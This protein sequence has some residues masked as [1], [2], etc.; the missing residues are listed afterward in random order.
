MVYLD[1]SARA[2]ATRAAELLPVLGPAPSTES[3]ESAKVIDILRRHGEPEP[4]TLTA[5]DISGMRRVARELWD[6]FAASSTEQAAE[7]LNAILARY[8]HAPRLSRH[9]AT[10]WHIHVDR[11]DDGPWT[12]WFAASSAMA[13]ATLLSERQTNPAGLC[14]SPTCGRPF[15][16]SGQGAPQRYCSPRCATRERVAAHRKRAA[17]QR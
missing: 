1:G 4:I 3:G 11:H 13:L 16:D 6:V 12:E 8:A 7:Q 2:A 10:A 17:R 14:A 15:V 5:K 9:D